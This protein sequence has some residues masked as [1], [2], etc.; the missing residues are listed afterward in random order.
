MAV[1]SFAVVQNGFNDWL[2]TGAPDTTTA[3]AYPAS[4]G[5]AA[6]TFAG[7]RY[8]STTTLNALEEFSVVDNSTLPSNAIISLVEIDI[9]DYAQSDGS[10]QPL[11]HFTVDGSQVGFTFGTGGAAAGGDSIQLT[12]DP[13]TGSAWTVS[14]VFARRF[15]IQVTTGVGGGQKFLV[16]YYTVSVAYTLPPPSTWTVDTPLGTFTQI[17]DTQPSNF[18]LPIGTFSDGIFYPAGTVYI[19]TI[20]ASSPTD[21]GWWLS[22]DEAF[23]GAAFTVNN[24]RPKNPRGFVDIG[25]FAVGSTGMLG[26]FPGPSCVWNNHLIYAEGGYTVGTTA[27]VIRIYDGEFDRPVTSLPNTSSGIVPNGIMSMLTANDQ[28]YLSTY[29]TGTSSSDFTGRV[30]GLDIISGQLTPIGDVFPTGHIPYALAWHNGRLWCGTHR[31][32]TTA[33]GQIFYFRPGIDTSW[34]SD[35]TLSSSSVSSCTSLLSYL[36]KLYVG[37]SAPTATFA[38]VLVRSELG[39]YSTSKTASGGTA[40]VNNCF[41]A[42]VQFGVNLYASYWNN[43]TPAVSLIYAYDG[44]SWTTAYTGSDTTN[45][46]FIGFP[47]DGDTMLAIGGGLGVNAALLSTDDG[48]TWS[49]RSAFLSQGSPASTGIPVFGVVKR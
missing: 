20:T 4:T 9:F 26:G 21:M 1:A 28:V 7:G 13:V 29:D 27:P 3:V 24:S 46:P 23:G 36:G 34:T 10:H 47:T 16:F 25:G 33:N 11:C 45:I 6:P 5:G 18:I 31:Q 19:W 42:L 15:G 40:T 12:T 38:K 39:V 14:N 17:S 43:D 44:T 30:F 2:P 41:P 37:T 22:I 49:D 32:D 48:T 35:Y 8:I